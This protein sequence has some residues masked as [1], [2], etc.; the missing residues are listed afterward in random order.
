MD[1]KQLKAIGRHLDRRVGSTCRSVWKRLEECLEASR[2][3]LDVMHI[4]R[5]CLEAVGSIWKASGSERG[6][7]WKE[8]QV[9]QNF[10]EASGSICK[11]LD[12]I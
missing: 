9:H 10:Q 12:G 6:S 8:M 4:S 1:Q 7:A 3:H 5:R 2:R 11:R